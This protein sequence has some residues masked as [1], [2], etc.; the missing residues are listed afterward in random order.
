MSLEFAA[1][2][3]HGFPIIPDLSDDAEGAMKTREAMFDFSKEL[4][5]T[6]T[7]RLF[8]WTNPH[9]YIQ[10]VVKPG[11]AVICTDLRGSVTFLNV[12]AERMT[13]WSW[14]EAS[15]RAMTDVFQRLDATSR[16]PLL[17]PAR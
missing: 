8:Q 4:T 1:I 11:D 12:V 10:L 17:A 6:G 15:G 5:L 13:G 14:K 7:V 9:S 16:A 3:P 2:V